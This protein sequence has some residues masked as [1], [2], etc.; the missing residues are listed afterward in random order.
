MG[1]IVRKDG[2]PSTVVLR[3]D[4]LPPTVVRREDGLPPTV[5]RS[6]VFRDAPKKKPIIEDK[7][8]VFGSIQAHD[9][10]NRRV[11]QS[12]IMG[13]GDP[14]PP[15][16]KTEPDYKSSNTTIVSHSHSPPLDYYTP[17][18]KPPEEDPPEE[19]P[20]SYKPARDPPRPEYGLPRFRGD[21]KVTSLKQ[22]LFA[23]GGLLWQRRG[24]STL[25]KKSKNKSKS[26][27][28]NK[29]KKHKY[30]RTRKK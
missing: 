10:L 6:G 25:N 20:P 5:S 2:R 27:S 11:N 22:P 30:K 24:G 17:K 14:I 21:R 29:T 28:K 23:P 12:D 7:P 16:I 9:F 19:N 26:K 15:K 13:L 4:D 18:E 3:E 1:G 8:P